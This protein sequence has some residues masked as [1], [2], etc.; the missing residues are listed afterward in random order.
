MAR[1][2]G[3]GGKGTN[4]PSILR[5]EGHHFSTKSQDKYSSA[6]ALI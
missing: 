2:R 3:L 6:E 5:D 4:I 1:G